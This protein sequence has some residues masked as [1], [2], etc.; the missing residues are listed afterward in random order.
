MTTKL[1]LKKEKYKYARFAKL[2]FDDFRQMASDDSLSR[3]EKIGFPDEYRKEKEQL[4]FDDIKDKLSALNENNKIIFDIG[5]GCSDLAHYLIEHCAQ[6]QHELI[7]ADSEEM[8]KLLPDGDCV[9]KEAVYFPNCPELLE[10]LQGKVDAIICYSVFHYVFEESNTWNFLDRSLALLAPG[11]CFL[12]GDIPNV[13][14]RKRFF[15]SE[16]GIQHHKE[17]MQTSE[18]PIVNFNQIE[19]DTID[20]SVIMALITRARLAGFDAYVVPQADGLPMANR[21]EDILIIRP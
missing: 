12:I 10:E 6:H 1:R 9:R 18:E 11:G 21:R 16:T 14:K 17:F 4:I 15:A 19:P 13:S 7:L 2:G 20:D 3:Y 8:L 5:P